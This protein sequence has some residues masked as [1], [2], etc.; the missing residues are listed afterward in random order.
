VLQ[1]HV[2]SVIGAAISGEGVEAF[3]SYTTAAG[4]DP[5]KMRAINLPYMGHLSSLEDKQFDLIIISQPIDQRPDIAS[6][7]PALTTQF[8]KPGGALYVAVLD[9]SWPPHGYKGDEDNFQ[10]PRL[11]DLF[12]QARL[13]A[14]MLEAVGSY[15]MTP[16]EPGVLYVAK[17][18]KRTG[19]DYSVVDDVSAASD[20]KD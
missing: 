19:D 20:G 4:L 17:G 11:N 15:G 10:H 16:F 7:I 5:E 13:E 9:M 3:T 1:P 2:K 12:G 6:V 8:L 18:Y 14:F